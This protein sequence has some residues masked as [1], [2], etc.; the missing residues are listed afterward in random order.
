MNSPAGARE[1]TRT[2]VDQAG[3]TQ[4]FPDLPLA[5]LPQF[6]H[7]CGTP[8]LTG[9]F[10]CPHGDAHADCCREGR[11]EATGDVDRDG[12]VLLPSD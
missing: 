1:V 9:G 5:L 4:P 11:I 12:D 8:L 2:S 10:T 6:C 7:V 3:G